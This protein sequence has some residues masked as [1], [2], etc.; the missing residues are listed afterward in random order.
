M[1]FSNSSSTCA[2]LLI[3]LHVSWQRF[4]VNDVCQHVI[5]II[6]IKTDYKRSSGVRVQFSVTI[7]TKT[8]TRMAQP[9][10]NNKSICKAQNL[11]SR[12]YS[13]CM[14]T[15]THTHTH[16][17]SN[18]TK[19]DLHSL[20][21]KANRL[22]IDED[23]S[24]AQK[25]WQVYSLGERNVFRLYLIFK[26]VQ[27][28]FLLER[29]GKVIPCR[30]TENRKDMGTNSEESGVRNLEAESIRSR[31]ESMCVF[32]KLK[33]ITEIRES[34]ACDTF[35]AESVYLVLNSVL[36][37]EPVEKLKQRFDVASF[38]PK[39]ISVWG[40]QH[41]SVCDEGFGQRKQAGQKGEN[42]SSQGMTEWVRWTVLLWAQWK[43]TSGQN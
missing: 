40:K 17:H 3:L 33:T 34:S 38:T 32:V 36:D 2:R 23:S 10:Y 21:W 43:D 42:C 16:K 6:L 24:T 1:C 19:P 35:I 22:E 31:A 26:W 5:I 7:K 4:V 13:K 9:I 25:T 27:R 12:N 14:H 29:K 8:K 41:R 11:V 30:W 20:K 37:W 18:Y 39:N 15:C 28:G